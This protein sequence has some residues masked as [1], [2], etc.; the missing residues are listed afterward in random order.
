HGGHVLLVE[1]DEI[2]RELRGLADEDREQAR[3]GG[4]EGAAVTDAGG[5]KD[6]SQVGHHLERRHSRSLLDPQETGARARA[7]DVRSSS[8]CLT[9]ARR[10][11]F[12]WASGPGSVQPAAFS[13]PPPPNWWATRFRGMLPLPRR[14]AFP[15]PRAP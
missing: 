2:W 13:W 10:V 12:A 6:P 5:A 4:I 9:A 7:H 14:V 15:R 8:A 1:I 3:R 11:L